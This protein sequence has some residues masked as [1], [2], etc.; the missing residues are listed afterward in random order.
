LYFSLP[1]VKIKA[2][3]KIIFPDRLTKKCYLIKII[4]Q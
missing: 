1:F 3:Q 4:L 2:C